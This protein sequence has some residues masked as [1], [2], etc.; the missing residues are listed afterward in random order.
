MREKLTKLFGS[1]LVNLDLLTDDAVIIDAGACFGN[2]IR[3]IWK[4]VK[5]PYIIAIEPNKDNFEFLSRSLI[6]VRTINAALVGAKEEK[7]LSFYHIDGL[8][9]WGNVTGLYL[10]K[11]HTSYMVKTI[12]LKDLLDSVPRETIHYLKMDIE[13]SEW[14]VVNDMNEDTTKRIQQISMEIHSN[15]A[16]IKAKLEDL[17]YKTYWGNSENGQGE[18]YAVR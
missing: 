15:G 8:S 3:D 18:L 9:E 16:R 12:N 11:A 1:H 4:H 13:G 6:K 2:F 5:N 17:G 10:Y 7:E 14:D